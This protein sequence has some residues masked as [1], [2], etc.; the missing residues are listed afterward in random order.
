MVINMN[1]GGTERALLNMIA[2][3]PEEEYDITILMLEKYGDFL[4]DIP[5]K[6]KV[7]YV[8]NYLDMKQKINHSP[9]ETIIEEFKKGKWLKSLHLLSVQLQAKISNNRSVLYKYLLKN[10]PILNTEYDIAIAYAGPMDFIS[11]FIAQKTKA[12]KKLQWIHFDVTT[13]GFNARFA[14]KTYPHYEKIYVVSE[15]AKQKLNQLVPLIE[16]KTEVFLNVISPRIIHDQAKSGKGFDDNFGGLR[17]LTVGRLSSEKGQDLAIKALKRLIN[18]GYNVKWY[19][20]GEGNARDEY[21]QLIK[22]NDLKGKFILLG[23]N[24]NPYP[25][26]DQCDIYVQPSRYEGYCITLAEARALQKPIV[27]T[28][29]TGAK[30]QITNHLTGL[31]VGIKEENIYQAV[32]GLIVNPPLRQEFTDNLLKKSLENKISTAR[33][34]KVL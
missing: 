17:I 27:T 12:K 29:F 23:A 26:I 28:N 10:T 6:V 13:I 18:Q 16:K 2:E 9:K 3:M 21:E 19:C 15:E 25:Y 4:N 20:I 34:S 32:E 22:E 8:A 1:V 14:S 7:K 31:I 5:A 30:E 11:Y 24:P 33:L